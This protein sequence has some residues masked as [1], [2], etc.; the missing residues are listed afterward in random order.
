MHGAD[1]KFPS[2]LPTHP[3]YFPATVQLTNFPPGDK[4]TYFLTEVKLTYF[5]SLLPVLR[6]ARDRIPVWLST[7]SAANKFPA[8][9]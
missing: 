8:Q 1:N 9:R 5:Y 3:T 4:Q 2:R 6:R 7:H